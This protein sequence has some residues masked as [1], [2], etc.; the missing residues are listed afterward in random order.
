MVKRI[1][2]SVITTI[3]FFCLIFNV[4]ASTQDEIRKGLIETAQAYYRLKAGLDID[5][6][7]RVKSIAEWKLKLIAYVIFN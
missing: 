1:K 7:C 2:K 5:N 4:K 3:L 6:I